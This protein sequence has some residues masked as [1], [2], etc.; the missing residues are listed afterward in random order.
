MRDYLQEALLPKAELEH[1][2]LMAMEVVEE[3]DAEQSGVKGMKWG[4]R[5][6]RQERRAAAAKRTAPA[7]DHVKKAVE[8][9]G[10]KPAEAAKPH[11]NIQD[12]VES[13]SARYSRLADQAKNGGASQMTEQDLKFF[14]ARTDALAKVAKMNE[15]K[16]GWLA[17]TSKKVLQTTAQNTMQSIADGVAKKYISGPV[18][19][20]LNASAKNAAGSTKVKD[21]VAEALPKARPIGFAPPT[22]KK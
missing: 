4:V 13:S 1:G 18:L 15:A 5:R 10:H 8:A 12:H 11:G 7:T 21:K 3:D 6:S 20:N 9:G 16:P 22:K 17:E 2:E 14:N 19:D